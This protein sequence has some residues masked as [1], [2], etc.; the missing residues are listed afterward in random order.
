MSEL[1]R[2]GMSLETAEHVTRRE[3]ADTAADAFRSIRTTTGVL[4]PGE[5]PINDYGNSMSPKP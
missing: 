2:R 1:V 4:E 3:G 5:L